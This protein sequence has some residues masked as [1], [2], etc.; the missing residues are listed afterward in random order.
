MKLNMNIPDD[1]LLAIGLFIMMISLMI[2]A[3]IF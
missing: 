3:V 1:I 2:T